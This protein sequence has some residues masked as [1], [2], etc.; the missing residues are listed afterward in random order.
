[1]CPKIRAETPRAV[2]AAVGCS[3]FPTLKMY[4]RNWC[5]T[6]HADFCLALAER[7]YYAFLEIL[8]E[9]K[10]DGAPRLYP[11]DRYEGFPLQHPCSVPKCT[12][13]DAAMGCD[14][15]APYKPDWLFLCGSHRV[16]YDRLMAQRLP[17]KLL[18]QSETRRR[19]RPETPTGHMPGKRGGPKDPS[20]VKAE[21]LLKQELTKHLKDYPD[22]KS[23]YAYILKEFVFPRCIPNYD[24]L[25]SDAQKYEEKKLKMRLRTSNLGPPST[26]SR[27][28]ARLSRTGR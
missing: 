3:E 27:I 26:A 24:N 8:R 4:D 6:H 10:I 11:H 22:V 14:L 9:N 25:S 13:R 21:R 28:P 12:N 18:W 5:P 19:A 23:R 1:M 20:T 17:E 15:F 7:F 2:C 16:F